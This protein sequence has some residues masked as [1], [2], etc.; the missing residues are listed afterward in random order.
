MIIHDC[1]IFKTCSCKSLEFETASL[2][3]A[4]HRWFH[5]LQ[6]QTNA[7]KNGIFLFCCICAKNIEMCR[8]MA[9]P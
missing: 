9:T 8:L 3:E 7:S 2:C 6:G 4:R 5:W 1:A